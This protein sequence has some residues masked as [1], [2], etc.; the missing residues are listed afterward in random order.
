[1][2]RLWWHLILG[3][4]KGNRRWISECGHCLCAKRGVVKN[5]METIYIT[6]IYD[7]MCLYEFSL[8]IQKSEYF[9]VNDL[10]F[11]FNCIILKSNTDMQPNE[12][13]QAPIKPVSHKWYRI[14]LGRSEIKSNNLFLNIYLHQLSNKCLFLFLLLLVSKKNFVKK[15]V[16]VMVLKNVLS[17][18][19]YHFSCNDE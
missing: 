5:E 3:L 17:I 1:M 8:G 2:L 19:V 15:K 9:C 7:I 12:K 11:L 18:P 4:P 16:F 13:P 14:N 10:W 6:Y